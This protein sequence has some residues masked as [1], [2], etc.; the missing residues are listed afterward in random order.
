MDKIISYDI[1][2][3]IIN[4]FTTRE[5]NL[6]K[7]IKEYN[8]KTYYL[9]NQIHSDIINIV[10]DNYINN[11]DGDGLITNN[12]NIALIIKTADCIPIF[13]YDKKNKVIGAIHSGWKGTLNDITGK[14]IKIFINKY[15][16]NVNDIYVY[17][18]PSIRECHFEVEDDVY[19]LFKDKYNNILN[20]TKKIEN[21]YYIDLQL[22]IKDNLKRLGI[23]NIFDKEICT[24]CS[25]K[26]FYS[27]RYNRTDE[28]N[29]LLVM[30]KE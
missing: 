15:N 17:I 21:K 13:I 29:Y 14:A 18:Y 2:N 16:S 12:K 11:S 22:I 10:D 3:D 30:I 25:N 28:R 19:N 4:L 27:Y 23:N 1:D 6:D 9:L 24:Y 20:Y 7:L 26:Y 5:Y 8:I